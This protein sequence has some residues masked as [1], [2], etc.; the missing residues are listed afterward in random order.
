MSS[1][2]AGAIA[3]RYAAALFEL[4]E[5]QAALDK[6]AEDLKTLRAM[7]TDSADLRR[8]LR[9]PVI[10][11]AEQQK[12]MAALAAKA[13]LSELTH[14]FVGVVAG[15]RRLFVLPAMIEAFLARL[16]GRRGEV[17]ASVMVA[18]PLDEKQ[19][20]ALDATLRKALGG[21]IALDVS[22][23]PSLL[24]G[25]VVRVGSRMIDSSLKT[26][27]QQLQLAMKGVA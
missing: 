17:K 11:R 2:T 10:G 12:A 20:G 22:V 3:E 7:V 13:G 27:L 15:N 25:L 14:R 9:S 5:Q 24:G 8:L 18:A 4:A 21:N 16:A 23:D 26:K 1:E 19:L 6:V